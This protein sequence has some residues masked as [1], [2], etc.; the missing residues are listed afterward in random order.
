[1]KAVILFGSPRK[2]GNTRQLVDA[3]ASTVKAS[4]KEITI[5]HLNDMKITPCQ[6]CFSCTESGVC[7]LDD[8]MKDVLAS[9]AESDVVVYATPIYWSA[10][11][12]QMKAAMDRCVAYFDGQLN[13][14][15]NG[16]KGVV[17]MSCAEKDPSMGSPSL[18]IFKR[19]FEGLGFAFGHVLAT[20]CA[21]EG[22]VA[23]EA[24][25]AARAVARS[26]V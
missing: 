1:M 9:I 20:G 4:Q 19:T 14:R 11:Y 25:D 8:D 18:E 12:A 10:P 24:L 7:R 21:D 17:L 3:F 2:D 13:S 23:P 22:P 15:V 5:L 16:K 6:G 26:L